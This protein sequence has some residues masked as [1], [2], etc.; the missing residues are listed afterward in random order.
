M[1]Q[2]CPEC[3]KSVDVPDSAAGTDFPCPVCNAKIAVPGRY[4]PAVAVPP[5][6]VV[7]PPPA[8]PGLVPPAAAPVVPPAA[9]YPVGP[10]DGKD[11]GLTL[12]PKLVEWVVPI[13][14]TL[15]FV[16][17]FFPW[18]GSYPGGYRLFMQTGWDTLTG[19]LAVNA[20][21]PDLEHVEKK[22][23][24]LMHTDGLM[25]PFLILLIPTML[26]GWAE[27]FV[28]EVNPATLPGPLGWLPKVWPMRFQLLAVLSVLLLLLL[29]VQTLRGFGLEKAIGAYV[30]QNHESDVAAADTQAKKVKAQVQSGQELAGFAVQGTTWLALT[31]LAMV[32]VVLAILVRTWLANRGGKPYP[33]LALRY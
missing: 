16:L 10:G 15:V 30:G 29:V 12:S 27:K 9:V 33:R 25:I 24:P 17:T 4:A 26:L 19:G 20:L 23:E 8:P 32:L 7:P 18:V 1:K 31:L 14:L 5:P 6:A 11:V 3:L 2:I 13:G 21:P 28:H 22:L